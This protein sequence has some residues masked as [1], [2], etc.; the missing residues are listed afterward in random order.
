M[1]QSR[2]EEL[3]REKLAN[4][5]GQYFGGNYLDGGMMGGNYLDGEGGILTAKGQAFAASKKVQA[6]TRE[7]PFKRTSLRDP[8]IR[9][10]PWL[11]YVAIERNLPANRNLTYK[12]ILKLINKRDY[13]QWKSEKYPEQPKYKK[14]DRAPKVKVPKVK[15]PKPVPLAKRAAPVVTKVKS[16]VPVAKGAVPVKSKKIKVAPKKKS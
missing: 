11:E 2:F 6:R 3:Y 8:A 1:D 13:A 14:T 16:R 9:G 7:T 5:G 10:N 12:E 4:R 15:P